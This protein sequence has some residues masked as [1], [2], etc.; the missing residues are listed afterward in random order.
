M[1]IRAKEKGNDGISRKPRESIEMAQCSLSQRGAE[2]QAS[3]LGMEEEPSS[4]AVRAWL[5]RKC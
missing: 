1:S 5:R 4:E 3:G 2:G